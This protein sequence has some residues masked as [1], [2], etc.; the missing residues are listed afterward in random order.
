MEKT[1]K[2]DWLV[3]QGYR[4]STLLPIVTWYAPGRE[5]RG[6][7]DDYTLNLYRGKGFVL[8]RKYLEPQL[9][10]ELEYSIPRPRMTVEPPRPPTRTPRLARA[11]RGAISGRD[12]WEGTS[13][14]LLSLIGSQGPGIPT[15]AAWLSIEVMKPH[16][17]DALK[18]YGLVAAR[19]RS[20]G[21]RSLQF[22][23]ITQ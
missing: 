22:K 23:S 15:I 3:A 13:S 2:T 14:E 16:I 18:H 20:N 1:R 12:F 7:T 17:T 10:H 19:R 8:D 5:F 6:R 4:P 11:I 21:K 9:W